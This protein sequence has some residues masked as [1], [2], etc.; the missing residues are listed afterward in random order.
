MKGLVGMKTVLNHTSDIFQ[1]NETDASV[2][3]N[4]RFDEATVLKADELIYYVAGKT[5]TSSHCWVTPSTFNSTIDHRHISSWNFGQSDSVPSINNI[6]HLERSEKIAVF[7][8]IR[9]ENAEDVH[10]E[11][12]NLDAD[13][14][15][16]ARFN[17][18][19]TWFVKVIIAQYY[20]MS[21]F[22]ERSSKLSK[23][24]V[25]LQVTFSKERPNNI[26]FL[27]ENLEDFSR[28][29]Y[30]LLKDNDVRLAG[31][32]WNTFL[33]GSNNSLISGPYRQRVE[34]TMSRYKRVIHGY[35]SDRSTYVNLQD[36]ALFNS[37]Q[38]KDFRDVLIKPVIML[39]DFMVLIKS[40]F[41]VWFFTKVLTKEFLLGNI[42]WDL[43]LMWCAAAYDFQYFYERS[44]SNDRP[45]SLISLNIN[46]SDRKQQLRPKG[47][48]SSHS[49]R[50][51][52]HRVLKGTG[53][54]MFKRWVKASDRSRLLK[55]SWLKNGVWSTR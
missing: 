8:K 10:V 46:D 11:M 12:S 44:V 40:N 49:H 13:V 17:P 29:D 52:G 41:A 7:Q 24:H 1:T 35:Q 28:F 6:Q 36:A 37:Y 39:E 51:R 9:I 30:V 4:W 45:C 50:K 48:E 54:F 53:E 47:A 27:R 20:L 23:D 34:Q 21:L 19:S 16:L 25:Q 14:R 26:V 3:L 18:Q 31:F 32:E 43:D 33:N 2:S 38:D 55:Y 22:R 42:D 5:Y 15:T